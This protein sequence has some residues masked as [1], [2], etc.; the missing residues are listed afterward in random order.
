MINQSGISRVDSQ[1]RLRRTKLLLNLKKFTVVKMVSYIE[2]CTVNSES[3]FYD[4]RF[5]TK[6]DEHIIY[7]PYKNC[8]ASVA[9]PVSDIRRITRDEDIFYVSAVSYGSIVLVIVRFYPVDGT[10]TCRDYDP[11]KII[12]AILASDSK[13]YL[14]MK[15]H[16]F[17]Q[18]GYVA[19]YSGLPDMQDYTAAIDELQEHSFSSKVV[20]RRIEKKG[21]AFDNEL[22]WYD[23]PD[24]P[25][26]PCSLCSPGSRGVREPSSQSNSP[27]HSDCDSCLGNNEDICDTFPI[28][29]QTDI[30][31]I[32]RLFGKKE[33]SDTPDYLRELPRKPLRK[34]I[35]LGDD[36][37]SISASFEP[38]RF[39][40][41]SPVE[42][43]PML[44]KIDDYQPVAQELIPKVDARVDN[45]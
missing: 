10:F 30:D 23:K 43:F 38:Y 28:V 22:D 12:P 18:P 33:R 29:T 34:I 27:L 31:E 36:T 8:F 4:T 3:F 1:R 41:Y 17:Y 2:K 45:L 37:R 26:S 42:L 24:M 35:N 39:I 44:E 19:D 11:T 16:P 25:A 40:S 14:E 6:I 13:K 9:N 7:T 15:G 5:G 32:E 20:S 21:L